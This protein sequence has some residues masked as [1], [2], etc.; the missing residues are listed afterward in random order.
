MLDFPAEVQLI[1]V[2]HLGAKEIARLELVCKSI[3]SLIREE[4]NGV[5]K[6]CLR[7]Q[8]LDNGLFWPTFHDLKT[9]EQ[10]KEAA[11]A[12][13]RVLQS[14]RS[15]SRTKSHLRP[16]VTKVTLSDD[17]RV[18][19]GRLPLAT[20]SCHEPYL[21]PGGRFLL[22]IGDCSITLWD[23]QANPSVSIA[24][25]THFET[26]HNAYYSFKA[27]EVTVLGDNQL[28]ILLEFPEDRLSNAPTTQD[29]GYCTTRYELWEISF[30][31]DTSQFKIKKL[32]AVALDRQS[33]YW[34]GCPSF[35]RKNQILED[36]VVFSFK[37]GEDHRCCTVVWDFANQTYDAWELEASETLL[38]WDIIFHGELALLLTA[39]K[40]HAY[41]SQSAAHAILDGRIFVLPASLSAERA[42]HDGARR[43]SPLF[44]IACD[45]AT[46]ER[47]HSINGFYSQHQ[48]RGDDAPLL[49]TLVA[50]PLWPPD[51]PGNWHT[52]KTIE[53]RRYKLCVSAQKYPRPVLH[54]RDVISAPMPQ[55]YVQSVGPVDNLAEGRKW[56]QCG[57]TIAH[58]WSRRLPYAGPHA[59]KRECY[60]TL[61]KD[62]PD[63]EDTTS[64][65][66][67]SLGIRD[68]L[69]F[70]YFWNACASISAGKLVGLS[71][72]SGEGGSTRILEIHDF[73]KS[74]PEE[75]V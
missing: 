35:T 68:S 29:H 13:S 61:L 70:S 37:F 57:G 6:K 72:T 75:G 56:F 51:R 67:V 30:D 40:I 42:G 63:S 3:A 8:C 69:R 47:T 11:S 25:Q 26:P 23:I 4:E 64:A 43:L 39:Q 22:E 71:S 15:A 18:Q 38:R 74:V 31:Y 5:W 21:V 1:V 55:P 62:A 19:A 59:M 52:T 2:S 66:F 41:S 9:T 32:G 10:F 49:Y 65:T 60:L 33:A 24:A 54:Q 44:T 73:T 58:L 53:I 17:V 16:H 48:R 20:K 45:Y 7:Q 34:S 27:Y 28:R 46:L 50:Y 14:Y 12:P 36:N